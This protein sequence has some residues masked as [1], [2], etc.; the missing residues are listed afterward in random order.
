MCRRRRS[1]SAARR[2]SR[3]GSPGPAPTKV[4]R[5]AVLRVRVM[6]APQYD[7]SAPSASRSAASRRPDLRGV[8]ERSGA[9]QP[10]GI[11]AVRADH[12]TAQVDLRP[13]VAL[14]DLGQRGDRG[15]AAG[16]QRGQQSP[17]RGD[18]GPGVGV[19]E[20]GE[21]LDQ[22]RS[23]AARHSTASAPC[24]GRGQHQH[25][26][27][28]LGDLVGA[29]QP[30]RPAR[31][32][33]TASSSPAEH[34]AQPGVHVAADRHD[35][36]AEAERAQLGDP[37]RRAGADAGA[38][39]QL[40]QGQAVP[41]DQRVARVLARRH[42]GDD[43]A[44]RPAPSA[45]PCT[46]APRSRSRRR[47]SASRSAETNTP[48]PPIWV[49]AAVDR[50]PAVTISTSST[51]L[52]E[53][54][55]ARRRPCRT[56]PAPARCPGC[57][58]AERS[59]LAL[60]P[61]PPS[62]RQYDGRDRGGGGRVRG[63]T[64]RAARPRTASPPGAVGELPDPHGRA[65]AAA[66]APPGARCGRPRPAGRRSGRAA[67]RPAGAAR[68]RPPR[69]RGPA[70]RPRSAR[71]RRPRRQPRRPRPRSPT[72]CRGPLHV[73]GARRAGW[74]A[75]AARP[76]PGV[77]PG[78]APT[79]PSTSRGTARSSSTSGRPA[80][81]RQRR[82]DRRRGRAPVPTAPVQQTTRSAPASAAG[83]SASGDRAGPTP[84]SCA[85][86]R[87]ARR[88]DRLATASRPT[89]ARA[90]VAAD[91]APIDPAPITSAGRP[92]QRTEHPRGL[93]QPRL[94]T[95][96]APA[97]SM[98]VSACT[99]LPTRSACCISSCSSRPAASSSAAAA[100]ASR[101]W[102]RICASPTTIESSP[103]ATENRCSTAASS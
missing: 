40:G 1:A 68:R 80:A 39:R 100:Y 78:R 85:A 3:P 89:P 60:G 101:S 2:V 25:R 91:S 97:R 74:P 31:A 35:L 67:G 55:P 71:P 26:V 52:A 13:C 30:A 69:R 44:R 48:M 75:P 14:G 18:R 99:R 42:G 98:P 92:A 5:P 38:G 102:P 8:G 63:R 96:E 94:T 90:R 59:S 103:A 22:A 93:G 76:G 19:V 41:G 32:S 24:A 37:A 83:R 86:S 53:A 56:G 84:P 49:S 17:L 45:G 88:G 9:G 15:G 81:R 57:R 16:L 87:S 12:R 28:D 6:R 65:R 21:Q 58:S 43:A 50:S 51:V 82:L 95:I 66:A 72:I 27:E 36:E 29:A 23:S 20:R 7:V 73:R 61:T 79:A 54:R 10:D 62:V 46:S 34:L 11:A 70:A 47:S 64:A 77:T 4:I 33:T